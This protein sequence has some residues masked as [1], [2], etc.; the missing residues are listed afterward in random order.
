MQAED[1]IYDYQMKSNPTGP[2]EDP[3]EGC[4]LALG[5]L[6]VCIAVGALATY[7]SDKL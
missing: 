4:F 2:D 7:L 3:K 1:I 6:A 5:L